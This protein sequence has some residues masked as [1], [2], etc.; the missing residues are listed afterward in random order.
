MSEVMVDAAVYTV[1]GPKTAAFVVSSM[2]AVRL[3]ACALGPTLGG[4]LYELGCWALPFFACACLLLVDALLQL[5]CIGRRASGALETTGK[6]ASP[7]TILKALSLPAGMKIIFDAIAWI[8]MAGF[9]VTLQP[10]LGE[11]PYNQTPGQIGNLLLCVTLVNSIAYVAAPPFAVS[12]GAT[13]VMPITASICF[14]LSMLVGPSPLLPQIPQTMPIQY[15][16]WSSSAFF[17]A[18]NFPCGLVVWPSIVDEM[19]FSTEQVAG[20]LGGI[21]VL[22]SAVGGITGPLLFATAGD[23]VSYPW[24]YTIDA[25]TILIVTEIYGITLMCRYRHEHPPACCNPDH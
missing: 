4:H 9:E 20:V 24:V 10:F 8:H 15:A 21:Q 6:K 3:L 7:L 5:L 12:V 19:G 11:A 16:A 14:G 25:F 23:Y 17:F 18:L 1:F 2:I 22:T 13:Y